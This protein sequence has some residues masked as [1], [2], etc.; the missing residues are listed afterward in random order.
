MASN[1]SQ[2]VRRI[3]ICLLVAG[4]AAILAA[5]RSTEPE[6][7]ATAIHEKA[8]ADLEILRSTATVARARMQTTLDHAG[9]RVA[10][11]TEAGVFLRNSLIKLGTDSTVIAENLSLVRILS[12]VVPPTRSPGDRAGVDVQTAPPTPVPRTIVTPPAVTPQPTATNSGPR[13]QNVVMSSGVND[14]DCAI[15]DNPRFTPDFVAIYVVARAYS[16]PAGATITSNWQRRGTEVAR[17]S[18]ENEY[19]INDSCI[20]FF[21]DQ[22]DTPFLVGSWSVEILVDG[23]SV[24]SPVA[25]QIVGN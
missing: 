17:F 15:D 18:F 20:W 5:C 25:F 11:A 4:A 9:T 8:R 1:G 3:L 24:T 12:T 14:L 2:P 19:A 10:Q 7:T 21:I 6:L 22:T 23:A 16:V 13:L